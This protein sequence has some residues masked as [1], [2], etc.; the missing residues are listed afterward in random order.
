MVNLEFLMEKRFTLSAHLI[1]VALAKKLS[2]TEFLLLMYFEDTSDK[3]FD[4][5]TIGSNLSLNE[6]EVL[7]AFNHLLELNLIKLDSS[8]D[9]AN[10]RCEVI[11]L[12]PMY[13]ILLEEK[14]NVRKEEDKQNIFDM[15]QHELGRNISPME[16]EII[17]AWLSKGFSEE[18]VCGAL[19]EA[20]Y[21]GVS[22]LRYM[23]KILYEW[24]KK[25]YKKMSD[26]EE[27]LKERRKAKEQSVELFD[28]N[29]LDD[30]E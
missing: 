18:L 12:E 16:Y 14:E 24:Q 1:E 22:S 26:V 7:N 6:T 5:N 3:T 2:L 9:K 8:K 25:G 23:D 21:H 11:S 15:F 28:Y 13:K 29:W 4:V 10:R 17:N 19:K 30:D 27:G 20:V